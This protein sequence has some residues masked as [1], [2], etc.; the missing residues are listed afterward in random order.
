M[1]KEKVLG[2]ATQEF[3]V[4]TCAKPDEKVLFVSLEPWDLLNLSTDVILDLPN[5]LTTQ[6]GITAA[7]L[8]KA[9][10]QFL[11]QEIGKDV[12]MNEFTETFKDKWQFK[13]KQPQYLISATNHYSW[14]KSAGLLIRATYTYVDVLMSHQR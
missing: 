11:V 7:Y 3:K 13:L 12:L 4:Y 9:L 8:D 2:V 5:Q 14:P 6:C 1:E 10:K